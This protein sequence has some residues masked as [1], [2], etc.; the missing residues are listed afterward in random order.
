MNWTSFPVPITLIYV[1]LLARITNLI[2][3]ITPIQSTHHALVF[4]V[5]WSI[6]FRIVS[7]VVPIR[8]FVALRFAV[9]LVIP[10]WRKFS[11]AYW[12]NHTPS[13]HFLNSLFLFA[14][15]LPLPLHIPLEKL[16]LHK[17]HCSGYLKSFPLI[18]LHFKDPSEM[19][20]LQNP[21]FQHISKIVLIL[22]KK[23]S[24]SFNLMVSQS[25]CVFCF[26]DIILIKFSRS[27][28][29]NVSF[30]ISSGHKTGLTYG[31]CLLRP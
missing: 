17:S 22:R 2:F 13:Q 30:I 10:V 14:E 21:F 3:P 8:N 1:R 29:V 24:G 28:Y 7:C 9:F 26:V 12:T 20:G 18:W 6:I 4:L 27:S 15:Y 23:S 31:A 16:F 5:L 25:A 11:S 19:C